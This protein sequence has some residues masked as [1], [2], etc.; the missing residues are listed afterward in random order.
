MNEGTSALGAESLGVIVYY[1]LAGTFFRTALVGKIL[2]GVNQN[3]ISR[4][5][6]SAEET[7][8]QCGNAVH[9][10]VKAAVSV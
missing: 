9:H 10:C 4:Q 2:A 6:S 3:R 5:I 8:D 1:R 7:S